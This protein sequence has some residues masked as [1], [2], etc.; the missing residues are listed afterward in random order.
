MSTTKACSLALLFALG[1]IGAERPAA[2]W[3]PP[4]GALKVI[5]DTDAAN[6]I[7][8]QYAMT[9]AFGFPERI[10]LEGIVAAH[11]GLKGGSAGIQKSYDE[12][13]RVLEYAGLTGKI[14]LKRGSDPFVY[15][16]RIPPSEGVDF[17][18][19]K[20]KAATPESPL[21]LVLLGPA[22]DAAAAL[23]KE[24]SIADRM[25]VFW[26][27]RTQWPVRCWNFNAYNDT[28]AAQFIFEL[29]C[30]M[31]LFDTGTH[32]TMA[33]EESERRFAGLGPLGAYLQKIRYRSPHFLSPKKG[34]FDVGDIAALIDPTTVRYERTQAPTVDHDLHYDFAHPHGEIVRIYHVERDPTFDLVEEALHKLSGK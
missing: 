34:F 8:D 3:L 16:D 11:F 1:A 27:G 15:R 13:Q 33:K 9:L 31:V 30:R 14:P 10:H 22:T 29:P 12:A 23:L 17:I 2:P 28:K 21:W 4:T 6:E 24:P 20:A 25:I 18:I 26:H 32:L 7:D 19:E 5:I